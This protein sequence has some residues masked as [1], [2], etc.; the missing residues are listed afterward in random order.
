MAHRKTC[1]C[2]G[3]EKPNWLRNKGRGM[4][5][6]YIIEKVTVLPHR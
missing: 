5:E 3:F 2:F 1:D 4:N 6:E